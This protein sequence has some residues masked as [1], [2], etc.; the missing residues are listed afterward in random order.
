M[1]PV[2][3]ACEYLPV[4][5]ANSDHSICF[6]ID[7]YISVY[8]IHIKSANPVHHISSSIKQS[9]SRTAYPISLHLVERCTCWLSKAFGTAIKEFQVPPMSIYLVPEALVSV[10]VVGL[11]GTAGAG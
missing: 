11:Y 9:S 4:W 3:P 6:Y 10:P 7:L 2:V 8:S 5:D 1:R